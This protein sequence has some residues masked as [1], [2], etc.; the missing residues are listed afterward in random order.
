MSET[1]PYNEMVGHGLTGRQID[2]WTTRGYLRSVV[3]DDGKPISGSGNRRRWASTERDIARLMALF[4]TAG[5]SVEVAAKAARD[6][7]ESGATEA[8]LA[9]G[10]TVTWQAVA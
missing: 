8:T 2:Y 3:G 6:A 9:N 1:L 7:I 4:I 5:L 10:L